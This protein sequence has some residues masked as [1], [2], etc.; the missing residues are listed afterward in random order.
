[1]RSNNNYQIGLPENGQE[2]SDI[3]FYLFFDDELNKIENSKISFHS[4]ASSY[5]TSF[6][7]NLKDIQ[8]LL[9]NFSQYGHN[10]RPI[11]DENPIYIPILRGIE[12][13][14]NHFK[15]DTDGNT[16]LNTI[17]MNNNQRNAI[18]EYKNIARSIYLKKTSDVYKIEKDI[19]FTAEDLYNDVVNNLLGEESDREFIKKFEKFIS[20]SFYNGQEFTI[21]PKQKEKYLSVKIA[22]VERPLH[23]FGDGI[24]QLI[25]LIYKMIEFEDFGKIFFIEEPDINLHPGF[26]RK[27][28]EIM[29]DKRFKNHQFFITTHSNHLIDSCLE[30]DSISIYR[31]ENIDEKY[32]QF[33]IIN[34]NQN[35]INLLHTLGINNSSVFLANCTIW[36]EGISDKILIKKY[37]EVYMKEHKVSRF[38]EDIHYSF[39]EYGGNNIVHWS[40]IPDDD[41]G[42]INAS[43]VTN[44]SFLICDNDGKKNQERKNR[45]KDIFKDNFYELNVREIENTVT[46][47]VLEKTLFKGEKVNLKKKYKENAYLDKYMGAFIDTHYTT[48]R[49]YKAKSGTINDKVRFAKEVVENISVFSDLSD[50][51]IKICKKL[52]DFIKESNS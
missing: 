14:D 13:F 22:D 1:M 42:T 28:M 45:L 34:S 49:S 31:F 11:K 21:I 15:L 37:L 6:K 51:A 47:N 41:I 33:R 18:E 36:V 38:K 3:D 16:I 48:N 20:E 4:D 32:K 7:G 30:Y 39:I 23:H 46:R 24:K 50:E 44:R 5:F 10:G 27:L 8:G 2:L 9:H 29:N 26:Q 17:T 25:V 43:G 52:V 40:F 19:I 12:N 35:D